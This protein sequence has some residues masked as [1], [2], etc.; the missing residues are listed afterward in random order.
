MYLGPKAR[1][2]GFTLVEVLVA[3]L[4]A[5]IGLLGL[6][7]L[8]I[9]GL[10]YNTSAYM[11]S[12]ATQ[13]AYDLADRMR[14]N[15]QGVNDGAYNNPAAAQNANCLAAAGCTP[16]EMAGHDAFEWNANVPD[17]L[18]E[19]TGI[20]CIDG[21]P[22]DGTSDAAACDGAGNV[23]V[24]KIWWRDALEQDSSGQPVM[25]RFVTSLQP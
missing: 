14:A 18:P 7:S 6:A 13:L 24:I 21:T 22:N 15:P 19:G 4:V 25:Q 11:R 20:V 5:A 17:W 2:S 9:R 8:Q 16:A 10:R 23:Y 12:Q 3:L 1:T